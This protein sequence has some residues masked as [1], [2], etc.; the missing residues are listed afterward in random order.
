MADPI[1]LSLVAAGAGMAGTAISTVTSYQNSRAQADAENINAREATFAA[2]RQGIAGSQAEDRQRR[3]ARALLGEQA[4]AT[5]EAGLAMTGSA[6]DIARQSALYAELDAL[7]IRYDSE[8]KR[9]GF[10]WE[11]SQAK[12]RAKQAKKNATLSLISGGLQMAGQAAG[13]MGKAGEMSGQRSYMDSQ[14]AALK[15]G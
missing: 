5:G 8:M 3:Q 13:A 12:A 2:E 11:S 9:R 4:A 10:N 1:T 15:K 14:T 7:N 6:K